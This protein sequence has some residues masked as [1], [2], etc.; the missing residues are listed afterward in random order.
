MLVSELFNLT[1]TFRSELTEGSIR[2]AKVIQLDKFHVWSHPSHMDLKRLLAKMDLRGLLW[3]DKFFIWDAMEA[4]HEYI[5]DL[6]SEYGYVDKKDAYNYIAV[7]LSDTGDFSAFDEW[8]GEPSEI[9]GIFYHA[10][11]DGVEAM[12]PFAR[13]LGI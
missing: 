1:R 3:A 7:I 12:R 11:Q 2:E 9:N 10:T 5:A 8:N 6:L 4:T 13:A